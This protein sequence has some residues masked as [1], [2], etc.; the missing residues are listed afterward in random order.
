MSKA[1]APVVVS[2][3]KPSPVVTPTYVNGEKAY[4]LRNGVQLPVIVKDTTEHGN[5]AADGTY[6]SYT[7]SGDLSGNSYPAGQAYGPFVN[8][9][10]ALLTDRS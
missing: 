4:Y 10:L 6:C 1:V 5:K 7:V 8:V 3:S 9:P 2:I